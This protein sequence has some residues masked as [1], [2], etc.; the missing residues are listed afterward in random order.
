M[1]QSSMKLISQWDNIF[2]VAI[3]LAARRLQLE[4][5]IG[6]VCFLLKYLTVVTHEF[7]LLPIIEVIG[8]AINKQ[9]SIHT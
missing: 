2:G 9:I 1:R 4:S 3:P 6:Y 8:I 7:A 5:K